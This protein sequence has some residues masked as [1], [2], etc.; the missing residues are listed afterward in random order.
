MKFLLFF[1]VCSVHC[2]AVTTWQEQRDSFNKKGYLWIK[3][4]YSEQQLLLLQSW[5]DEIHTDAQNILALP[6]NQKIPG[7]LIVV[8]EASDPSQ[9]CRTEDMLSLYPDLHHFVQGTVS[10]F[11]TRLFGEPY[12]LFKDKLNFKWPGGGAFTPHQDFPA[13]ENFSPRSHVTAMVCIDRASLENGCL[14][15]AEEWWKPLAHDDAI[16]REELEARRAILPYIIGGVNHGSIEP[17]YS[18]KF[19]WFPLETSPGDLVIFTSF[20]PHYSEP[21]RSSSP[22]RAMLFTLNKLTEGD[23]RGAYYH[24]KREDPLNPVFHIGTP[25]KARTK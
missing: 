24:A 7:L 23:H 16:D 3:N 15:V 12:V 10:S 11:L 1:I 14:Q 4:F 5:A 17:E 19:T 22:R 25:T 13:Y 6:S 2:F 21:N 18:E 20:I 8:P 9:V